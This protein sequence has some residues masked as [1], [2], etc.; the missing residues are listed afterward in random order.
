M[1]NTQ[2]GRE[3]ITLSFDGT[4]ALKPCPFCGERKLVVNDQSAV[5]LR[6]CNTHTA[7][8][9]IQCSCGAEMMSDTQVPC[10]KSWSH[11]KRVTAH[12]KAANDAIAR[13][14]MRH[15]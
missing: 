2:N 1:Y 4:E 15:A 9:W 3:L 11:I 12:L 5:G 6:L 13:W 8:Y 14:N 10:R 7:H